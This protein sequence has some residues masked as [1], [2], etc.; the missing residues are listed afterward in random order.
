MNPQYRAQIIALIITFLL[1]KVCGTVL[2]VGTVE[3]QENGTT[4]PTSTPEGSDNNTTAAP[5]TTTTETAA[6]TSN[7]G[8]NGSSGDDGESDEQSTDIED[9]DEQSYDYIFK[10][11]NLRIVDQYWDGD[12]YVAELE[13]VNRAER[14]IVTDAGRDLSGGVTV[15]RESYTIGTQGTTEIRFTVVD[16]RA[17]TIDDGT[18]LYGHSP[19]SG[20]IT[21]PDVHTIVSAA[22]GLLT[23][24]RLVFEFAR[25]DGKLSKRRVVEA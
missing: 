25:R 24:F 3:A 7:S 4:T 18:T 15:D 1:L 21:S 2:I 6:N 23:A 16:D 9:S 8:D 17:V 5:D 22:L 10:G 12:T 14:V 13:A 19:E 11:G 20:G